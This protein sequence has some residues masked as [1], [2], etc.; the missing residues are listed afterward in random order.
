MKIP[1]PV[2]ESVIARTSVRNYRDQVISAEEQQ[3]LEAFISD[4]DNPFAR[5][6]SFHFLDQTDVQGRETLGTYGV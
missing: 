6:V 3:A 1:F 5:Q 4:L 2:K